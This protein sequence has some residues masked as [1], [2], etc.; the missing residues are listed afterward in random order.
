MPALAPFSKGKT[1]V[2]LLDW[3]QSNVQMGLTGASLKACVVARQKGRGIRKET[4]LATLPG[5]AGDRCRRTPHQGE[6]GSQ[7]GPSGVQ[8]CQGCRANPS[9]AG[10]GHQGSA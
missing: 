9:L 5:N 2:L 4:E 8:E 1:P 3:G 10:L 6:P 7:Q